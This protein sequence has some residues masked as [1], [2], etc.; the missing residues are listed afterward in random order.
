MSSANKSVTTSRPRHEPRIKEYR[1]DRVPPLAPPEPTGWRRA[2]HG[3]YQMEKTESDEARRQFDGLFDQDH[4]DAFV[5]EAFSLMSILEHVGPAPITFFELGSGRAPWCMAVAGAVRFGFVPSPPRSYRLLAVEAEP[6]HYEWTKEHLSKQGIPAKVV[7]GAVT[8]RVGRCRFAAT[9]NPAA[10]MGQCVSQDG[11]IEVPSYTIDSLRDSHG[12]DRISVL[13]MDIQGMEVEAV[14]GAERSLAEGRID[15]VIVGTHGS[16]YESGL[17]KRMAGTH[18][19]VVDLPARGTLRLPGV[20]KPV[21]SEAD[22]VH[23]YRRRDLDSDGFTT[24]GVPDRFGGDLPV[25]PRRPVH[26]GCRGFQPMR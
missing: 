23:V 19:L 4:Y 7:H 1:F 21:R 22:G 18:E 14:R 16:E 6:T 15:Y 10:H 26:D 24:N 12:F 3:F 5:L 2:W 20:G 11:S 25:R 13:H 8:G 9:T 17:R